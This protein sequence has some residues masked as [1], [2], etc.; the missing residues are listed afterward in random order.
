M[1]SSQPVNKSITT[2][3]NSEGEVRELVDQMVRMEQKVTNLAAT[4]FQLATS[5]IA[6]T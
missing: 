2:T 3:A 6:F 4:S 1:S 5:K